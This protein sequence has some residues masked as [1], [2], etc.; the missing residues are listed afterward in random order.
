MEPSL[1]AEL[2]TVTQISGFLLSETRTQGKY[3]CIDS[4]D[5]SS[6]LYQD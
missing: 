3:S 5:N 6:I 1:I 2:S 4:L